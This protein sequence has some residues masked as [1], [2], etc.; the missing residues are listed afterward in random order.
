MKLISEL[1]DEEVIEWVT[2]DF[3]IK[4]NGRNY[5]GKCLDQIVTVNKLADI[6][7]D[8][9]LAVD[10][11]RKAL[12]SVEDIYKRKFRRGLVATFYTK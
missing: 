8:D 4:V 7:G 9:K 1:S 12:N 6:L 10:T 3:N 2:K 5:V 11:C